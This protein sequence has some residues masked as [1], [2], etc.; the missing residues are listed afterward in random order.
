VVGCAL[1]PGFWGGGEGQHK[2]DQLTEYEATSDPIAWAA[3]FATFSPFDVTKDGDVDVDPS[4]N[5]PTDTYLEVLGLSATGGDVTKQ[6]SFKYIAARLNQAAFGVPSGVDTLLDDI[7]AY[8]EVNHVGSN[9]GG[10]T[11]AQGKALFNAIN[12]YF[13]SVGEAYCPNTGD[14]P[15]L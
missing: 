10:A 6:L 1:S 3:G 11:K 4:L 9:P 2:W 14:I 7:A 8:L 12:N 13:S 5:P 15:E